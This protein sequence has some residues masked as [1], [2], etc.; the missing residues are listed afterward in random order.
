MVYGLCL[1]SLLYGQLVSGIIQCVH[2]FIFSNNQCVCV[3]GYI[4][5]KLNC[6]N[7]I[8]AINNMSSV[9]NSEL[10]KR[11]ANIESNI[12]T[13]DNS[14]AQN[15]SQLIGFIQTTQSLI[16]SNIISN[17]SSLDAVLQLNIATLDNRTYRNATLL[18]N[19]IIS[20]ASTLQQYI[21]RNSTILDQRIYNNISALNL[22]ITNITNVIT[23]NIQVIQQNL[24]TLD[25]FTKNFQQNQSKQN[26]EMKQ[27]IT[28]LGQL[29]NCL[30]NSGKIINGL[31]LANYT[32]N[33][34]ENS[35]C[36]Q[37]VYVGA[38]DLYFITYQVQQSNF[39]NDYVFSTTQIIQDSFIDVSD[40]FN[41][42]YSRNTLFQ[43]QSLFTNIK[44]QFGAQTLQYLFGLGSFVTLSNQNIIINQM[45]IISRP[46]SQI[47]VNPNNNLNILAN[48]LTGANINNLLVN[49]SFAASDGNITLISNI[50]GILN[51][52]GYQVLGDYISTATV[53][54]IGINVRSATINVN[55]VSV[56]P[57]VFN[58]GNGSSYLF[59]YFVSSTS[60]LVINN[61]AVIIGNSSNFLT[62][63]STTTTQVKNMQFGGIVT[64]CDIP[65]SLNINNVII[66]SYIQFSTDYVSNS[67]FL[68]G[69]IKYNFNY[70][71]V[72]NMCIKQN[73]N[74]STKLQIANSGLI[75]TNNGNTSIQNSSITFTVQGNYFNYFGIV[76]QQLNARYSEVINLIVQV[77]V[78][79]SKGSVVGLI[80]GKQNVTNC[81]VQNVSIVG[82]I[83]TS[84]GS[85]YGGIIGSSGYNVT[86]MNS[87]VSNSIISGSNYISG[88]IGYSESGSDTTILN[89]LVQSLNVSGSGSISGILGSL[90]SK[91]NAT[92]HNSSILNSNISG[93]SG[94]V[95]SILG[96]QTYSTKLY[97]TNTQIQFV[98]LYCPA[99]EY[100]GLVVGFNDY[101][102]Q[103][104]TNSTSILV[105]INDILK[106]D[107]PIL[108]N[109]SS[110]C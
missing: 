103:S 60:I 102:I 7:I 20:N 68:V 3:Y 21:N 36:S 45:N 81:S 37:L 61:F 6:I 106:T 56:K 27:V 64:Q 30:N 73:M 70:V 85:H 93:S 95:G 47:T 19:S 101:G 32:V 40:N 74:A 75:G 4:L 12:Q 89:S 76:G 91:S 86:I 58:V 71:S 96:F 110:G 33:C 108:T 87:S 105:Y 69:Y 84:S 54:M 39:S 1:D 9:D 16:E 62:L 67:G 42:P 51:I 109:I 17:Y 104:L 13:L 18:A 49:L 53:A 59:G 23:Q 78:S 26:Q 28:T 41:Q 46:S 35:S 107:C 80:F 97:L 22:S 79:S 29:V 82:N 34:S 15:A 5:D 38:Y 48:S 90:S 57:N 44:I 92:V 66:D 94:S 65:P 72:K 11:V 77:S 52:S 24:T 100:M 50:T 43:S 99:I 14:I 88:I 8:Q 2:P 10:L 63:S 83:N 31:C 25:N 55:Q 98:R